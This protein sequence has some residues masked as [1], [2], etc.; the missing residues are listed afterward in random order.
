MT[1]R[2]G[3]PNPQALLPDRLKTLSMTTTAETVQNYAELTTD[4][5]PI[6]LDAAFAAAT[7]F[8]RPILHGTIALSLLTQSIEETFGPGEMELDVRFKR[9]AEVGVTLHAGGVRLHDQQGTYTVYV[10]KDDSSRVIE[11]TLILPPDRTTFT[12][13]QPE[14]IG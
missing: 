3:S 11:G 6:H 4:F 5:N 14:S 13:L 8:G 1:D 2:Q 12:P 7:P 9:P 10:E